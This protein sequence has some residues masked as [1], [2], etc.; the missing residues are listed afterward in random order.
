[1]LRHKIGM[2]FLM[3]GLMIGGGLQADDEQCAVEC[4]DN[5]YEQYCDCMCIY[6]GQGRP[7]NCDPDSQH[8]WDC[9]KCGTWLCEDPVLFR[10]FVADPRQLTYSAGWRFNDNAMT[11]NVIPVSFWDSIAFYRWF[12]VWPY[13]G[14]LEISLDGALWACFD[15]CTESAPL[16]NADYYGGLSVTYAFN[17]WSFR[18]RFYHISSHIGDEFLLNHPRFDRRNPSAETLDFFFSNY[19]TEQL[20]YYA[21]ASVVVESDTSFHC[22]KVGLEA[23]CE[24]RLPQYG[25]SRP[26]SNLWGYPYYGMH[27]R[28]W[29]NFDK[30]LDQTYVIGYEFAKCSG[31]RRK[32]RFFAEYHDGYSVEGQFA[33]KATTYFSLN[34]SYGY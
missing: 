19:L 16:L 33:N 12:N 10:P 11:K 20:R 26:C 18:M 29:N 9:G 23:G 30:H 13:C 17:T 4:A 8:A 32:L 24:V 34:T 28:Y 3:T 7:T 31:L 5:C 2:F 14:M 21:G 6:R 25:V 22:G 1:M 27:F 15:P